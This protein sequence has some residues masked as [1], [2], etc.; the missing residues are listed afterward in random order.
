SGWSRAENFVGNGPYPLKEWRYKQ[1]LKVERNPHYWGRDHVKLNEIWFYTTE[2]IPGEERRFRAGELHHTNELALAKI[3]ADRSANSPELRIEPWLGAYFYRFNT[4]RPPFNDVRVRR[5]FALAIDREALV[6]QVTR[7]AHEPAYRFTPP[8]FPG[9][10]PK[11]RLRPGTMDEARRLL[12]DAG[13]PGGQGLPQVEV[14]YNT[15]SIHKQ[16]AEALQ[17]MWRDNLGVDVRLRNEEWSTYL[18]SQDNLNF[19]MSRS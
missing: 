16:V 17:A 10:E 19:S 7:G 6:T 9:Y 14:L 12:A 4:T 8:N 2:D 18:D 3:D 11:A 13:Y 5:A 1:V 15:S